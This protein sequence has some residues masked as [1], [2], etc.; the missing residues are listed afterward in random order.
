MID[1]NDV[2]KWQENQILEKYSFTKNVQIEFYDLSKKETALNIIRNNDFLQYHYFS[3]QYNIVKAASFIYLFY[4]NYN[5]IKM[6]IGFASVA[7]PTLTKKI[8]RKYFGKNFLETVYSESK[9]LNKPESGKIYVLSRLVLLPSY[10][11][12]GL[13]RHLLEEITRDMRKHSFYFE[14]WS[15]MF[16]NYYFAGYEFNTLYIDCRKYLNEDEYQKFFTSD[17]GVIASGGKC[18]KG[19][20][21][22]IATVVF[23]FKKDDFLK[24]IIKE[25]YGV[26]V[27]WSVKNTITKDDFMWADENEIP[28]ILLEY[29]NIENVKQN[30][31]LII[32]NETNYLASMKDKKKKSTK[33]DNIIEGDDEW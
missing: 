29:S 23:D 3:Q 32:S 22:Y 2:H 10:R 26:D 6:Y 12:L 31:D 24:N 19:E 9:R 17:G 30:K 8:R 14:M 18:F 27:D 13:S 33:I 7:I 16:H 21:K 11:G 20:T 25:K 15:N 5:G 4:I 1:F 28:M